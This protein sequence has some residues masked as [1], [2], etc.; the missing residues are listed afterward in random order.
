[1]ADIIKKVIQTGDL[2]KAG[3]TRNFQSLGRQAQIA[4]AASPQHA[5]TVSNAAAAKP[6]PPAPAAP[7]GKGAPT[8]DS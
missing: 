7:G 6:Q 2:G 3:S 5:R 4:D 8:T 1:M